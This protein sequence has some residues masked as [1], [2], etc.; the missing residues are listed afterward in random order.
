MPPSLPPS[1]VRSSFIDTVTVPPES[2]LHFTLPHDV[3]PPDIVSP[4]SL[5]LSL[6]L[7]SC[8]FPNVCIYSI[9]DT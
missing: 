1:E 9:A 4:C 7:P 2:L 6:F 5:S 3:L 8:V